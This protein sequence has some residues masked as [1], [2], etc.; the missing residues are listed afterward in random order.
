M[1]YIYQQ[2]GTP[3]QLVCGH[4]GRVRLSALRIGNDSSARA[5]CGGA[6]PPPPV[7]PSRAGKGRAE[8][9]GRPTIPARM[10]R[11]GGIEHEHFLFLLCRHVDDR[12]PIGAETFW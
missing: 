6:D 7:P 5:A 12:R 8:E 11:S 4:A 3:W 10:N 2:I 9:R 1:S